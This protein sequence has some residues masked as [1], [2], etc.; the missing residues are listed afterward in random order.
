M[1]DS[2][3]AT[4]GIIIDYPYRG[5]GFGK[6]AIALIK[7]EAKKLGMKKLRLEV[8]VDNKPAVSLYKKSDFKTTAK[9]LVMENKL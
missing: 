1:S 3:E 6:Q 4:I 2:K 5:Q 7:K 8:F 9:V